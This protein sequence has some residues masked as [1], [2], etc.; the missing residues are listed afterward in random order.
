MSGL[1]FLMGLI[2]GGL[3][4]YFYL[5]FKGDFSSGDGQQADVKLA[6]AEQEVRELR[7]QLASCK[8]EAAQYKVY[9]EQLREKSEECQ[10]LAEKLAASE[11]E[12]RKAEAEQVK[13]PRTIVEPSSEP[14]PEPEPEPKP[15]PEAEAPA[16]EVIEEAPSVAKA[17]NLRKIEGI[18]PKVAQHLN[19]AGIMSFAQ[20]A[21]AEVA[22]LREI[23]EAA[24][25]AYKG[26]DPQS[27]PE[28][29]G[30]AAK[31]EWDALKELQDRLDG[32]RYTS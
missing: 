28:Q 9:E 3:I 26:M 2:I 8:Q 21:D 30:L 29:A 10:K 25:P 16:K 22:R 32:G 24:G 1:S 17:D 27:W 19:N 14:E 5:M 31:E 7:A 15:K 11:K 18:G 20:L 12:P 6:K 23:L 4:S 13:E